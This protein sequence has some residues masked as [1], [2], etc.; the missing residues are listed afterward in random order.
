MSEA[1]LFNQKD[2]NLLASIKASDTVVLNKLYREVYPKVELHILRNSGSQ[3]QAKD[4]FQ[5]AIV[6]LWRAAREDRIKVENASAL[7]GY[8]YTIA[9]NKWIDFLRSSSFKKEIS[10]EKVMIFQ[11]LPD[12]EIEDDDY[13]FKLK[14][15]KQ[16]FELIGDSCKDLLLKFYFEKL[17]LNEIASALGLDAASARNKKYRCMQKLRGLVVSDKPQ[18]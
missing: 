5:E 18:N 7:Q 16:A 10:S 2:S 1:T 9:K 14:K 17:S 6:A 4:I 12:V 13:E 15:A 8:L 11:E 3:V